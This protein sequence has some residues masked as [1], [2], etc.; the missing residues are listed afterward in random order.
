AKRFLDSVRRCLPEL[1]IILSEQADEH[2]LVEFCAERDIQHLALKFDSGLGHARNAM[3]DRVETDFFIL[4]DD[5]YLFPQAP[6]FDFCTRFLDAHRK[7][8]CVLG[9]I[10]DQFPSDEGYVYRPIDRIKNLCLDETGG[11]LVLIP[12]TFIPPPDIVFEGEELLRCDFG[13][14]WGVF[15]RSFFVDNHVRWD[16]Q[17]KIGG[18]EHFDFF[19]QLKFHPEKPGVAYWP[20]LRCNHMRGTAESY[21]Q[22]RWR[23]NWRDGFRAKW[24]LQYRYDVCEVNNLEVFGGDLRGFEKW[25]TPPAPPAMLKLEQQLQQSHDINEELRRRIAALQARLASLE[26]TP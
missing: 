25:Q 21:A 20:K 26:K 8:V 17:Y 2:Q 14:N 19:L 16:E 5:D 11:A 13:P 22:L 9:G 4:T 10:C 24:G 12:R 18:G 15:R 3:L 6:D 7:F 1:P 23:L